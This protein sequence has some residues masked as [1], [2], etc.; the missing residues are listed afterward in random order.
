MASRQVLVVDNYDSFTHNLAQ[1]L[2]IA[3]C[4]VTVWRNDQFTLDQVEA[5]NPTHVVISP[6]PGRPEDAG[7]SEAVIRASLGRRPVLGVCLGHQ[8][9]C[10]VLGG[11]IGRASQP[12]HGKSSPI[13]HD[14]SGLFA[15]LPNPLT[16]GRYHSLLATDVPD[17]LQVCARTDAG[18]VMAVRMPDQPVYGVQ[19]H[20]ESIL[21]PEGQQLLENFLRPDIAIEVVEPMTPAH[22]DEIVPLLRRLLPDAT[23]YQES[24]E[25]LVVARDGD[26][27]V[28]F[29]IGFRRGRMFNSSY[30]GVLPAYRGMGIAR[31]LM[32]AQHDSLARLLRD[33]GV[34]RTSTANRFRPMLMLNLREGFVVTGVVVHGTDEPFIQLEKQLGRPPVTTPAVHYQ[35]PSG[36]MARVDGASTAALL[37]LLEQGYDVVGSCFT[38]QGPQILL[39]ADGL[40]TPRPEA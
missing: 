5:L 19:F 7:L 12:M 8:A 17:A 38:E 3:G 27:A 16:V 1:G 21:T 32:R 25:H 34:I 20:P 31:R 35:G 14:G 13:T 22:I 2:G 23:R 28:G 33:G 15:G 37:E 24:L 39:S 9:L 6:G 26:T 40:R 11:T 36:P 10:R 29:K 18:E 4:D 30:G